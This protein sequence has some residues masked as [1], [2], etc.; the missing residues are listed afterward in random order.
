MLAAARHAVLGLSES[1]FSRLVDNGAEVATCAPDVANINV[2]NQALGWVLLVGILAAN[3]PQAWKIFKQGT[4]GLS[5]L[6][7]AMTALSGLFLLDASFFGDFDLFRCCSQWSPNHCV[8]ELLSLFQF[9]AA[10]TGQLIVFLLYLWR[11]TDDKKLTRIYFVVFL[12]VGIILS[13]AGSALVVR[14]DSKSL[15][16]F[17]YVLGLFNVISG[18]AL[19]APQIR[20][21]VLNKSAGSLSLITLTIQTFGA[22]V[23]IYFTMVEDISNIQVYGPQ[24]AQFVLSL[25]LLLLCLFYEWRMR[26]RGEFPPEEFSGLD[27]AFGDPSMELEEAT[28]LNDDFLEDEDF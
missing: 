28:K 19:Y 1:A 23:F 13:V 3:A 8:D 10:F 4:A 22:V 18:V 2:V 17:K 25:G 11:Q 24:I 9:G 20:V 14:G 26:R 5:P 7:V 27:D 16:L 21:V 15:M 12:A 6:Y